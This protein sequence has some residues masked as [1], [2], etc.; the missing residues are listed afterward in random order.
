MGAPAVHPARCPHC[1]VQVEADHDEF[2]CHGCELAA[3]LIEQAGLGRYYEIR[4]APAPRPEAAR[5]DWS[6]VPLERGPDGTVSCRLALDGL[7]CASCVWVVENVL[8]RTEGVRSAQVSYATGRAL[9]SWDEQKTSLQALGARI[10]ALGYRPR[11]VDAAPTADR[12]LLVR[13][14]VAAFCAANVMMLAVTVY[15]GWFDGMDA[16]YAT[17]FRWAQLALTTPVALW[18]AVPFYRSAWAGLRAGVIHMDLPIALAVAALYVHGLVGTPLGVEGYLDSLSMLVTLLLAGRVL[19]VRGRRQAA[20]AASA[21]A[22]GLP[23]TAR[24]VTEEGVQTVPVSELQ[25]GDLV[26]VGLGEEVPADGTVA[27]GSASVG[28]SLL[29]GE[30][31]PVRIGPGELV[32]A[33]APVVDGAVAVRVV[34]VGERTLGRRMAAEVLASVDRPVA[35]TPADQLAPLFTA[36]SLAAAALTLIGWTSIGGVGVGIE[37]MA[38]VLVVACPCALGL[39]WPLAVSAGL[40][41]L[42][43][44][45][46][47]L[48]SGDALQRLV[49]LDIIALDKTGTVT[50]GVPVV[51][52]AD[53]E[54]LRL[55]AGLERASSHPIAAAIRQ[56]AALRGLALPIATELHEEPGLGVSG[57]I[58]GQ[59][60]T[61]RAGGPGE[62]WLRGEQLAGRIELRDVR[63][64]DAPS[65][66]EAL[67]AR[68]RVV[69]LTGDHPEVAEPLARSLGLQEHHA[70]MSP[71]DKA[72]WIAQQQ[73]QGR[74]VLFVGD[75]LN[76]GPA[77][78]QADL[79]LAMQHG[80]P[81]SVL[82]AD[83]IVFGEGLGPVLAALKVAEVVQATVR[84]NLLRSVL[85]NV[86]A[87]GL[88]ALGFVDPLVAALLMPAS[89]LLVLWGALAVERR[90]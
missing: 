10:A 39:S 47:L 35:P 57:V 14:G 77:L 56:A 4:E 3:S 8:Q 64:P 30:S 90:L 79:G 58:G 18:S 12:D 67:R 42:A 72:H 73:L 50:G 40:H 7:Q 19:E 59:R 66:I 17:L 38:A 5:L 86:S 11:P 23:S 81:S 43:R 78:V 88:A 84:A 49:G 83:G 29:T 74:R 65:V 16:R 48:R 24:R 69:M 75:G 61:L 37:R 36:F 63:R 51:V 31:E 46:V 52:S 32:V 68:G 60:W 71:Q 27:W 2:C 87:V 9:L 80:A 55:A 70:R 89:S 15:T 6:G 20:A 22:A 53:D 76:D 25:P 1:G 21:I 26:E 85:Y 45:G 44:R 34:R 54:V 62:V 41:A 13:L 28:L 82:A 33:G